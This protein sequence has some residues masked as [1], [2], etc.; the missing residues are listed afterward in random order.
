MMFIKSDLE[1]FKGRRRV[2]IQE[3]RLSESGMP[4]GRLLEM[5]HLGGVQHLLTP[6]NRGLTP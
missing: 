5:Q 3:Y 2:M 4:Y 6:P 1:L